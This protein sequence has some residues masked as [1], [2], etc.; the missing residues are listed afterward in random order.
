MSASRQPSPNYGLA[1]SHQNQTGQNIQSGQDLFRTPNNPT[2]GNGHDNHHNSGPYNSNGQN[3]YG[4][5]NGNGQNNHHGYGQSQKTKDHISPMLR[6]KD[7]NR[8]TG[9]EGGVSPRRDRSSLSRDLGENRSYDN[10]RDPNRDN[11]NRNDYRDVENRRDVSENRS[12]RSQRLSAREQNRY[13]PG[14]IPYGR[15]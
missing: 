9:A 11:R 15:R 4:P 1:H 5:N 8:I 12:R 3:N 10:E 2:K 14:S 6:D 13:Q 7:G